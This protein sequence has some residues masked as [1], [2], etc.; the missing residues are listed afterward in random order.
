MNSMLRAKPALDGV[1]VN[2]PPLWVVAKIAVTFR[3]TIRLITDAGHRDVIFA[4][5]R[6][7]PIGCRKQLGPGQRLDTVHAF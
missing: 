5:W 7:G 3:L 1:F 2:A 4:R 6:A